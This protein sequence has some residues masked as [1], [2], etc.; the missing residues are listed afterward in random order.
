MDT[1]PIFDHMRVD[2]SVAE[3]IG[4]EPPN[5]S[6]EERLRAAV[7]ARELG[8]TLFEIGRHLSTAPDPADVVGLVLGLACDVLGACCGSIERRELGGWATS[9]AWGSSLARVG[10]FHS[11]QESPTLAEMKRTGRAAV[12]REDA[13]GGRSQ[14]GDDGEGGTPYRVSVPLTSRRRVVGA[15]TFCFPQRSSPTA[16]EVEFA[17]RM[18]TL[19]S[20][21]ETNRITMR[22]HRR[23]AEAFQR[24][25]INA[26]LTLR[27]L[28]FGHVYAPAGD[29]EVAGGDF[30]DIF[31]I[32][33]GRVA[34]SIGDVAGRG[35]E[36]ASM[37]ALV[38]DSI[39]VSVLD[40]QGPADVLV[41]TNKVLLAF[42]PP[43]MFATVFFGV[44]DP[45]SGVMTYA[46]GGGPLPV[47]LDPGGVVTPLGRHGPLLGVLDD[48]EFDQQVLTLEPHDR[49]VMFTNGLSD[50]RH[51]D[52][53]LD[54]TGIGEILRT[55]ERR[56]CRGLA[57]EL[58]K[59]ALRF[60]GGALR[61]DVAI[62]VVA[63]KS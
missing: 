50:A 44:I 22:R 34:I 49:L 26:P 35:I 42:F 18:G 30:Y 23:V 31:P 40:A 12:V 39:R 41:R 17:D 29:E 3:G 33:G 6:L 56:D 52:E 9:H 63:L 54:L 21:W 5:A 1:A 27:D 8:D 61:D 36:A 37:T 13:V 19:L 62:L 60:A 7:R 46:L 11:D 32:Q 20:I 38:R 24:E 10:A 25:L 47:H 55:S 28:D 45:H 53:T 43:E 51:E 15:L 14:C 58:Y 48:V 2:S 57:E 4:G 59:G 16:E